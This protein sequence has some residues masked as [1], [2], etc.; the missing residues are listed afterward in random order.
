M[1]RVARKLDLH[2]LES[3]LTPSPPSSVATPRRPKR[4]R[5]FLSPRL[6]VKVGERER[7]A[8]V[9]SRCIRDYVLGKELGSGTT[10]TVY[11]VSESPKRR[12][13]FDD[14]LPSEHTWVVKVQLAPS[15]DNDA[16][17]EELRLARL[18]SELGVAPRV[19]DDWEC[20]NVGFI[21]MDRWDG[22]ME[23]Q[24]VRHLP[25]ALVYK[26]RSMIQR[27]HEAGYVHGDIMPKNVLVRLN[28]LGQPIDVAL[29]DFGLTQ[30]PDD[31]RENRDFL[32]TMWDYY[33]DE[34]NTVTR[35]WF[36]KE[37]ITVDDLMEDPRLLDR[38]LVNGLLL[39]R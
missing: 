20:E 36:D 30:T 18:F 3:E 29:A 7:P 15:G 13:L 8:W 5:L 11:A 21:V 12:R 4:Q 19:H 35:R 25:R 10:G 2:A 28:D 14:L 9:S 16:Y 31:W 24:R 17:H 38:A 26:L 6:E 39:S 33:T 22:S 23:D 37:G 27:I 1:K 34:A 32:Q